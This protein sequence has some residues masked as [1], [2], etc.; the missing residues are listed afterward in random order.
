MYVTYISIKLFKNKLKTEN[1]HTKKWGKT[2]NIFSNRLDRDKEHLH[3]SA[4]FTTC[5]NYFV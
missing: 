4:A 2:K 1:K 5:C 3:P